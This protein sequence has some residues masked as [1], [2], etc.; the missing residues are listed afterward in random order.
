MEVFNSHEADVVGIVVNN[1]ELSG[2]KPLAEAGIAILDARSNLL[3]TNRSGLVNNRSEQRAHHVCCCIHLE[4]TCLAAPASPRF[5]IR[6][7]SQLPRRQYIQPAAACTETR[8]SWPGSGASAND[9]ANSSS[10]QQAT[11]TSTNSCCAYSSFM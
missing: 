7:A 9:F 6:H 5:G 3:P 11:V 10:V 2:P 4:D 1:G 8:L